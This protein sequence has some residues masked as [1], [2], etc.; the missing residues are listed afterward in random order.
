MPA[1]RMSSVDVSRP[2]CCS[3][4]KLGLPSDELHPLR[5][6]FDRGTL[7]TLNTDNR[8]MSATT[9]TDEFWYASRHLD[10]TWDEL[11]TVAL[12]GFD[13][14]F[15]PWKERA[16]LAARAKAEIEAIAVPRRISA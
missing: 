14:A 9:L 1:L 5:S 16:A 4:A 10:F 15:L 8:L 11:C 6:Y 7:V 13:S 2:R 3:R 12:A